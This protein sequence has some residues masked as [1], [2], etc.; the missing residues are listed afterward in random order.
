M[1]ATATAVSLAEYLRT[2]YRPDVEFLNGELKEK[3]VPE[4]LHGVIQGLT[5][6]WF[7][8]HRKEW[9]ILVSVETRT[10]VEEERFRLPDVVVVRKGEEAKGALTK[11]PLIAIEVLSPTDSYADLRERAGDLRAMGTENVWLLDPAT[12]TAEVWTGKHWQPV[13]GNRLTAVNASVFLDLD[14]LWAELDDE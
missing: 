14:W 9:S 8:E 13:E 11:S 4:F 12:R 6:T 7:R 1:A 5:F 3:P 2:A 10:Q